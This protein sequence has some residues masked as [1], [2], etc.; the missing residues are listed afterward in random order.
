MGR[1]EDGALGMALVPV[2]ELMLA[3]GQGTKPETVLAPGTGPGLVLVPE[4]V[5][6]TELELETVGKVLE[7]LPELVPGQGTEL[8]TMLE[9]EMEAET[10]QDNKYSVLHP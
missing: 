7:P 5:L 2:P 9:A 1:G 8:E 4:T 3:P 6:G 10:E